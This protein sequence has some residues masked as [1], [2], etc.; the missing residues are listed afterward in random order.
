MKKQFFVRNDSGKTEGQGSLV[1]MD[2]TDFSVYVKAQMGDTKVNTFA[3][4]GSSEGND[5]MFVMECDIEKAN[6]ITREWDVSRKKRKANRDSGY[7]TVYLSE[8]DNEEE[9]IRGDEMIPDESVN[10][11][12]ESITNVMIEEM[13]KAIKSLPDDERDLIESLFLSDKYTE[14]RYGEI[15]GMS[16]QLIH[17]KKNCILNKLRIMLEGVENQ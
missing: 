12:E 11:E 4:V 9:S 16:Q 6:E 5:T 14:K 1:Q 15:K 10:V 3:K 13:L 2:N 8:Y 17:Y 7:R